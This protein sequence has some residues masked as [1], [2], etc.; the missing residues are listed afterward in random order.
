MTNR[1]AVTAHAHYRARMSG[2]LNF[3]LFGA[4][5]LGYTRIQAVPCGAAVFDR[6]SGGAAAVGQGA[7]LST[8]WE[9]EDNV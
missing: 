4:N 2:C 3:G 9:T 6:A 7:S 1:T 5:V 8:F